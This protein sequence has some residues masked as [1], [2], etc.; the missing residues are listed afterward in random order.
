VL[1]IELNSKIK[2]DLCSNLV[3]NMN[4]LIENILMNRGKLEDLQIIKKK[5]SLKKDWGWKRIRKYLISLPKKI[6]FA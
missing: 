5:L 1:N 6:K 2:C 4:L 3:K